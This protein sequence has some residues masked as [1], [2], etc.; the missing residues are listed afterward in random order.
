[1]PDL[2]IKRCYDVLP[3]NKIRFGIK[4]LNNLDFAISDVDVILDYKVTNFD[5]EGDNNQHLDALLPTVPYLAEFILK[6]L[7]CIHNENMSATVSFK[8]QQLQKHTLEMRPKEV[9]CISPFLKEKFIPRAEFLTISKTG[10]SEERG[11]NYEGITVD[12]LEIFLLHIC[13]NR[14]YNVGEFSIENSKII[15]FAGDEIGGK[16]YYLLTAIVKE[17]EG[18]TQLLLSANSDNRYGLNG[19][20]NEIMDNLRH[21]AASANARERGII[22]KEQAIN[23]I[24]SI[25]PGSVSSAGKGAGSVNI[26]GEEKKHGKDEGREKEKKLESEK[27]EIEPQKESKK[28]VDIKRKQKVRS[29]SKNKF[30]AVAIILGLLAIATFVYMSYSNTEQIN[31]TKPEPKPHIVYV[32]IKGSQFN[33]IELRI[34]QG[35]TVR[36]TNMDSTMHIIKG[37][38]FESSPL[39]K[40]DI[41]SYTFDKKGTYNYSCTIHPYMPHGKV[42]VMD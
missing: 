20:L 22:N 28:E 42:T 32:E 37:D 29:S 27:K 4:I 6:P 12:K 30:F 15:Y 7:G 41:W 26:Q 19:F 36:W 33:P 14:L 16:S 25:A 31:L 24:D 23:I 40:R 21:I 8:D 39:N 11:M 2:E 18:L 13:K 17:Y 38:E 5:L 9:H 10:F 35:T 1:M 34:A 3:N